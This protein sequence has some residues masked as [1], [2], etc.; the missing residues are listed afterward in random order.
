MT[1]SALAVKK[2][3]TV[4]VT[5]VLIIAF[6]IFSMFSMPI[7]RFPEMDLPYII[8]ST[9]YSNAGPEEV[10]TSVTRTLESS[11]SGVTGLKKLTSYS[12]AGSSLVL[13]EMNYGSNLDATTG[14]VR[15][16]IDLV[17]R[18][19]PTDAD[20]PIMIKMDPSM[21]PIML[22][23]IDGERTPEELYTYGKDVIQKRLE[24]VDGIA[25]AR[26][27][28]GREKCIRV[29][30]P[31]DRLEAY[32]LTVSNVSQMIGVQNIQSSG[33][34]ITSGDIRYTIQSSGKYK[35]LEDVKNTVIS[36]KASIG[37][38][39]IPVLRTIK[40]KDIADVYEGYKEETNLAY[41]DGNACVMLMIQKQSG[42]NS[43]AAAKAAR[44]Q[45]EKIEKTLPKDISIQEIWNSTDDIEA[46][47]KSVIESVIEGA[48]LAILILI[49]FLRSFKSTLI[50]GLSIP[51][52]VMATLM[53]M[54][55]RGMT[56]NM[57]SLSG[58]LIGIGMLVD[59]SI[60]V[61]ENIYSYRQKDAKPEVAATLGAQEMIAAITSSTLTTV[62][63]FL[64]MVVLK[65]RLGFFGQLFDDLSFTIIF[66]LICSLIVAIVLVPVL[67]SKYLVID[68]VGQK[69][70]SKFSG[71]NRIFTKFFDEMDKGYANLVKKVLR[72]KAMTCVVV[73]ILFFASIFAMVKVGYQFMPE[74]SSTNISLTVTLPKGTKLEITEATMHELE[75][76]IRQEIKG[77]KRINLS[78]GGS[79]MMSSSADTNTGTLR[80][81]LY[82]ENERQ[83]GWDNDVTA[84]EKIIP[85][86]SKFPGTEI[87]FEQNGGTGNTGLVVEIRCD[88]IDLLG[89]TAKNLVEVIKEK[90][91]DYIE[92][93]TTDWEDGL[94]EVKISFDRD[95]MYSLGL[96]V[97]TV[98][99]EIKANING[100]TA[101]RYDDK[102]SE[103]DI[104]VSLSDDDKAKLTDLDTIF[105]TNSS[106]Q[107]IPLSSFAHYEEDD[108]P[109]RITRV[110][111]ARMAKV[112]VKQ[113]RKVSIGLVQKEIEKIINEAIPQQDNMIINIS[114]DNAEFKK[115]G[116]NLL[117]VI[118]MA[119]ALVFAVM[120]SQFESLKDPFIVIF[121]MPLSVIGVSAI[122]LLSG[123]KLNTVSILGCLMLVGMIVNNGIVL[124][125][126]TNL[127]MKRGYGLFDACV[128][129]ARSR[130]RPILMSTLTTII[131]LVPMAF[132]ASEGSELIQPISLTVLGGLS[133]GS[134]M[135]LF[136][137][138]VLYYFFNSADERK[139][140]RRQKK[141]ARKQAKL[142]KS[143]A[144]SDF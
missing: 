55:L 68:N 109:V 48:V 78:V 124:V 130:L 1:L 9:T 29:D 49:V 66:S 139:E 16:K 127:L 54:F 56:L 131:S 80:L 106:G 19:L 45:I 12:S 83:P 64:P 98:G 115:T 134:L 14:E 60:V 74:T 122:H 35:S 70:D 143:K 94:P 52:S 132:F 67:S 53:L 91:A 32:S 121:T 85:Y 22:L 135:T 18:Y 144:K 47:I 129:A 13:L 10:E 111:Q 63:I 133:F 15:D 44:S 117:A 93:V 72:H 142:E 59:N 87:K 123:H 37:E 137:M 75:S 105:V 51:I 82:K 39:Q 119:A 62:C 57:I 69:R 8:V 41:L 138:P 88:E 3:T 61:L 112:T 17:R 103:I 90:A 95:R 21:M 118:I 34:T 97:Y 28:G 108:A 101:S 77:I 96:N 4:L 20:S 113:N 73:V 11:L 128:E 110:D 42:K 125:D 100:L 43:V 140:R 116:L 5:F 23:S 38:D 136:V 120:A 65:S 25:S 104:I 71:I 126:Y 33:G 76:I 50:V 27:I 24:Q 102:G 36:W 6:G 7:D 58:L 79:S 99:N 84:R 31:R 81:S 141:L 2:P 40:L 114:G 46:T 86:F 107:R 92:E 89:K 30:I 26:L